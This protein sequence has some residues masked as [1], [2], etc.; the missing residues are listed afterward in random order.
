ME[1]FWSAI[2]WVGVIFTYL[3]MIPIFGLSLLPGLSLFFLIPRIVR[4][5]AYFPQILILSFSIIFGFFLF[6]ITLIVIVSTLRII[7]RFNYKE[8]NYPFH[9]FNVFVWGFY[10]ALILLVRYT[11]MNW[12]KATPI[13]PIFHRLMGAKVGKNVQINT[14]IIAD[15][16]LLEIGDGTIIGG[17][18]QIICHSAENGLLKIAK[19]KIGKNV[20]I[21][22]MAVI[23]PGTE[24]GDGATIGACSFVPKNSQIPPNTTWAGV[25][26]RRI[27]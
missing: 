19:T 13:L 10:N 1:K 11:I 3:L 25:P 24:I 4:H 26:I 14:T 23:L 27:K 8:G 22:I 12:I 9:S 15:S 21:G 2:Q 5:W 17:D 20:T 18:A 7:F 16:R 6:G